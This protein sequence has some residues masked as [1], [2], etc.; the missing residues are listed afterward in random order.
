MHLT[1]TI[2]A[3]GTDNLHSYLNAYIHIHSSFH[4]ELANIENTYSLHVEVYRPRIHPD[5]K[6]RFTKHLSLSLLYNV[7][8]QHFRCI[9]DAKHYFECLV[10]S[11]GSW[12]VNCALC[13]CV[14][15]RPIHPSLPQ[16]HNRINQPSV[17]PW[18][19]I[20]ME[21]FRYFLCLTCTYRVSHPFIF[22]NPKY[23]IYICFML[24]LWVPA[25]RAIYAGISSIYMLVF[26]KCTR[27]I[28]FWHND[29]IF[30]ITR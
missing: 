12:W 19:I 29:S 6:K 21:A 28:G 3:N 10:L 24:I 30:D 2:T 20:F 9:F 14:C 8:P 4:S 1:L 17:G 16:M 25:F 11:P 18:I 23:S 26:N 15:V 27:K 13:V 5:K 22:S 7:N